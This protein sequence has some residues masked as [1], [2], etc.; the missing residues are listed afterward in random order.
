MG[1]CSVWGCSSVL[2]TFTAR[3]VQP[4]DAAGGGS[5]GAAGGSRQAARWVL[6]M[7]LQ[8]TEEWPPDTEWPS[9]GN[10]VL[11]HIGQKLSFPWEIHLIAEMKPPGAQRAAPAPP[12]RTSAQV[13]PWL[14][15]S[16]R[17]PTLHPAA[18]SSP[19]PPAA[20]RLEKEQPGQSRWGKWQQSLT[21][22]AHSHPAAPQQVRRHLSLS[23]A[24]TRTGTRQRDKPGHCIRILLGQRTESLEAFG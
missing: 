10:R 9:L 17:P 1:P 8:S 21:C 19:A 23:G 18:A 11:A 22:P 6:G 13:W 5:T 2:P 20:G 24:R 4:V 16:R 3:G 14:G 7:E 12:G 15:P